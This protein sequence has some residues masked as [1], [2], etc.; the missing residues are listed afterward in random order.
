MNPQ[1]AS[2]LWQPTPSNPYR[3]NIAN[4]SNRIDDLVVL[5]LA[6]GS[7]LPRDR[8]VTF[9]KNLTVKFEA[10]RVSEEYA[11]ND[12]VSAIIKY[13]NYELMDAVR[14]FSQ[15]ANGF[16][17]LID[18]V[19]TT[20]DEMSVVSGPVVPVNNGTLYIYR[21]RSELPEII[22]NLHEK[23]AYG[24]CIEL[25][26]LPANDVVTRCT[27]EAPCPNPYAGK[28][29]TGLCLP[30]EARTTQIYPV[31]VPTVNS[32]VG[33]LGAPSGEAAIGR[34]LFLAGSKNQKIASFSVTAQHDSIKLKDIRITG[35]NLHVLSNL[36]LTDSKGNLI[37]R[38]SKSNSEEAT[39]ANLNV[40]S[41]EMTDDGVSR[42]FVA[43]SIPRDTTATYYVVADINTVSIPT[44]SAGNIA[45]PASMMV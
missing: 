37:G 25:V 19:N 40:P 30:P 10:L 36:T 22:G 28:Y 26:R 16:D 29:A 8:Y 20:A 45:S 23:D 12:E 41:I 11:L 33:I 1:T 42:G 2:S 4:F 35:T 21:E 5:I 18:I 39:F 15:D 44:D 7:N 14:T 27:W 17:R 38:A 31:E 34:S 3:A 24:R 13:L 9:L 32:A 6:R 43:D